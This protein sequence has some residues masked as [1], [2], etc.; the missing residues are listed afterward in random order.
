[1]FPVCHCSRQLFPSK[2]RNHLKGHTVQ[3]EALHKMHRLGGRPLLEFLVEQEGISRLRPCKAWRST[4]KRLPHIPACGGTDLGFQ[5]VSNAVA[6]KSGPRSRKRCS[7]ASTLR[8][9][10]LQLS[11]LPIGRSGMSEIC[12]LCGPPPPLQA[13]YSVSCSGQPAKRSNCLF[14]CHP[15]PMQVSKCRRYH[16]VTHPRPAV[17]LPVDRFCAGT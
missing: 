5:P 14:C 8:R 4:P 1:M 17:I 16:K 12:F 6:C 2:N 13:S 9:R 15:Y 3:W 11:Y 10:T 7:L